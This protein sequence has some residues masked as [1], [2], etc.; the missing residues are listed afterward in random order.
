VADTQTVLQSGEFDAFWGNLTRADPDILRSQFSTRLTNFYRLP[1]TELDDV[2]T[3]QAATPDPAARRELVARAQQLLVENAWTVPVVEL[4]TV[5][6]A[7]P[8]VQGIRFD[9]SSRIHL[10]DA[11]KAS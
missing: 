11:W 5:L 3:Q 9:A 4:T 8:D 6:A 2:L 1:P 10:F 7:G